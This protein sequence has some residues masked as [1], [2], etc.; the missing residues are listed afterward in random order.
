MNEKMILNIMYYSFHLILLKNDLDLNYNEL[1]LMNVNLLIFITF[2]LI[3]N[4]L[5][6]M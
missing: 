1:F 4:I 2:I 3:I 6:L 5:F